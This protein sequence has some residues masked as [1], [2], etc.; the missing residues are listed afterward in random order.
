MQPIGAKIEYAVLD[1]FE[2]MTATQA[3][4][5]ADIYNP[6]YLGFDNKLARLCY[7]IKSVLILQGVLDQN[8]N[9]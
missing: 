6:T 5:Y 3:D 4:F 8:D 7:Y 2:P 1:W 9:I